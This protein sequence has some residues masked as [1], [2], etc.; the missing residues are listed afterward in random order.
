MWEPILLFVG[1]VGLIVNRWWSLSL[2]LLASGRVVYLLGY[3]SWRAIH[4]AHDVP[5]FSW[6]AAEKLWSVIYQ[7]HPQY[8]FEVVLAGIIFVYALM[9][10]GKLVFLKRASLDERV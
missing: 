1:V 2:A 9:V 7:P 8:F 5:M 10:I 3:L 4:F 6:Q